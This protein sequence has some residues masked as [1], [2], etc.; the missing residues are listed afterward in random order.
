MP[1]EEMLTAGGIRKDPVDVEHNGGPGFHRSRPPT[2]VDGFARDPVI[3]SAGSARSTG[4]TGSTG[5]IG[6]PTRGAL[7]TRTGASTRSGI[8]PRDISEGR[9]GGTSSSRTRRC[10]D[11]RLRW[12]D[13]LFTCHSAQRRSQIK[14]VGLPVGGRIEVH[15]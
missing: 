9:F 4:S 13:A 12:S 3:G 15:V 2:P 1:F 7:V 5:S 14:H 11:R 10:A 6:W 8:S